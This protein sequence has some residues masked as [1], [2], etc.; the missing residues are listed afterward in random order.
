MQII[1]I[2]GKDLEMVQRMLCEGTIVPAYRLRVAI[3]DGQA[4]FKVNEGTWT[5]PLGS[6]Q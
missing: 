5:P 2:E 1:S 4:K 3:E 6:E